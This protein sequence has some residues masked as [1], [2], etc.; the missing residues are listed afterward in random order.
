[1]QVSVSAMFFGSARKLDS[2]SNF[3]WAGVE[4][5][6]PCW[7]RLFGVP[8]QSSAA[9]R[10]EDERHEIVR[11]FGAKTGSESRRLQRRPLLRRARAVVSKAARPLKAPAWGKSPI[12][13]R[14]NIFFKKSRRASPRRCEGFRSKRHWTTCPTARHTRRIVGLCLG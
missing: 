2:M 9:R 3:F 10:T 4:R 14:R 5:G 13:E 1:V 12:V 7:N 8:N 11:T 6:A